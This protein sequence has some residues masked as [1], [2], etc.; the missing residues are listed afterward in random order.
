MIRAQKGEE[1][2]ANGLY[3]VWHLKADVS[4]ESEKSGSQVRFPADYELVARIKARS[5]DEVYEKTNGIDGPWWRG[6][7]VECVVHSRSTSID[8][9]VIGPSGDIQILGWNGWM[10]VREA[11]AHV[12]SVEA[13]PTIEPSR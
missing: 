11:Q 6:E 13:K 2:V 12:Q 3:D 7:G 4:I 5:L 8:D 9:V 10:M 1:P